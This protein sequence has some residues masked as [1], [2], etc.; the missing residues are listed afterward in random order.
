[1]SVK[2]FAVSMVVAAVLLLGIIAMQVLECKVL[3]VF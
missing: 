1:M 2:L 3:G